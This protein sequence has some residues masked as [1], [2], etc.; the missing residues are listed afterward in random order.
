MSSILLASF[1]PY[2]QIDWASI[3]WTLLLGGLTIAALAV[4]ERFETIAMNGR[5]AALLGHVV[6]GYFSFGMLLFGAWSAGRATF[7]VPGGQAWEGP[8][9]V[10]GGISAMTIGACTLLKHAATVRVM[11]EASA[12]VPSSAH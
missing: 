2:A 9:A 7:P 3:S 4:E 10:I 6:I 1:S 12:T 5:I 11:R 8:V